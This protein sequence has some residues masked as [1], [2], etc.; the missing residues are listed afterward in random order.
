MVDNPKYRNDD[1]G[2]SQGD[3]K[4]TQAFA[5]SANRSGAAKTIKS[6]SQ[7]GQRETALPR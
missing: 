2:R 5:V 7:M 3:E 1:R 6:E 4:S